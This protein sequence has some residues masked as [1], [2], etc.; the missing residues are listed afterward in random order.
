[1]GGFNNWWTMRLLDQLRF[2]MVR[3][4]ETRVQWISDRLNPN[5]RDFRP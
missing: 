4:R 5:K 3:D 2:S 1:V